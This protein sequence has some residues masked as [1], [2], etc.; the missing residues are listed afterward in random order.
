MRR[1]IHIQYI[2]THEP[3]NQSQELGKDSTKK[4]KLNQ[5]NQDKIRHN[6]LTDTNFIY[7]F[8]TLSNQFFLRWHHLS[9]LLGLV[10]VCCCCDSKPNIPI[11]T[12][13][14]WCSSS[15]LLLIVF[16]HSS[17]SLFFYILGN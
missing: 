15:L 14:I 7:N 16:S 11:V 4:G 10:L 13:T 6:I 8:S 5:H 2:H 9:T 1:Y 17:M 12:A 3:P